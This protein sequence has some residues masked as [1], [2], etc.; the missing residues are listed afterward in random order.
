MLGP[1]CY[2]LA[3]AP[4]QQLQEH[5][6]PQ[7]PQY[8]LQDS[9]QVCKTPFSYTRVCSTFS[10][11]FAPGALAA[12]GGPPAPGDPPAPGAQEEEKELLPGPALLP[13]RPAAGSA[14]VRLCVKQ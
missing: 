10:T 14:E 6:Q 9:D 4:L 8:I 13:P 3:A 5:H 2:P 12:P 7:V 11:F 1:H